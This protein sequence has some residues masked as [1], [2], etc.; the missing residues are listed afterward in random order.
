MRRAQR[1]AC[2][3][4][5][6]GLF[7]VEAA[8]FLG[9]AS[10]WKR[11]A[12]LFWVGASAAIIL[13]TWCYAFLPFFDAGF[14]GQR[15]R[16]WYLVAFLLPPLLILLDGGGIKFTHVDAEGLQQLAAGVKLLRTDPCVGV[17]KLGYFAYMARQYVLNALPTFFLGPSLWADRIGTSMFFIGSY[18]FFLAAL[19]TYFQRKGTPEP[20]LFSSFC[21]IIVAF[22]QFT[23]LNARKFEQ[24]AMP[25][26]VTLFFLAALL[27]FL[28][29]PAPLSY[30]WLA[31]SVGFFAECYT[32]A[33]GMWGLAMVVLVYLAIRFRKWI[34]LPLVAYGAA[35]LFIA[36]EIVKRQDSGSIGIK[37]TLGTMG[38]GLNSTDWVLR[39]LY[40]L[41]SVVG[42]EYPLLPVPLTLAIMAAL[43]LSWRSREYRYPAICLWALAVVGASLTFQGSNV[44]IPRHDIHRAMIIIPPLALG[45]VLLGLRYLAEEPGDGG[46]FRAARVYLRLS[47]VYMVLTGVSVVFLMRTFLSINRPDDE[48]EAFDKIY[49]VIRTQGAAQ[50]KRIYIVPPLDLDIEYGLQYFCPDAVVVRQAP[51]EGE[52]LPG[53]WVLAFLRTKPDERLQDDYVHSQ[54]PRPYLK[55]ERE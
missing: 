25:V 50:M 30:L 28:S 47:M 12:G 24:T 43:C 55:M 33:L 46:R 52:K 38:R 44:N 18:L 27:L 51:P 1:I 7:A 15:H 23:L 26:A 45:T 29:R 2:A 6:L 32:P 4:L 48:D 21:G 3:L 8:F 41:H 19:A 9:D 49:A 10:P 17:Y 20:L 35:S 42:P 54:N 31:W 14:R 11:Y 22:N 53:T 34:L 40:G 36:Y 13:S 16:A 39:Y 5:V 37:F